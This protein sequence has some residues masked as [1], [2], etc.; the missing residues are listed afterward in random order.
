MPGGATHQ[1]N[2]PFLVNQIKLPIKLLI[3]TCCFCNASYFAV[4]SLRGDQVQINYLLKTWL[5]SGR[6]RVVAAS[7]VTSA[8]CESGNSSRTAAGGGEGSPTPPPSATPVRGISYPPMSPKLR[9][10]GKTV[11]TASD[12]T[13]TSSNTPQVC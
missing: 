8:C 4:R 12:T 7:S 11:S 9:R 6:E 2:H 5:L 1:R 3:N 10:Q 13:A